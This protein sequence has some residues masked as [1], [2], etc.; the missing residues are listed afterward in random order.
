[1][2]PFIAQ[3]ILF[4]G[5]FV[6]KGWA[7]C[8]GQVLPINAYPALFG[9]LGTTYGGDGRTTFALPDLRGRV[10]AHAGN[11]PGLS[12]RRIGQMFGT[13]T[14]TLTANQI[15]TH[16]HTLMVATSTE[17]SQRAGGGQFWSQHNLCTSR[18]RALGALE[19][20]YRGTEQ[21]RAGPRQYAAYIVHQLHHRPRGNFPHAR[22]KSRKTNSAI[23][24][25][26]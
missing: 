23:G 3:I 26:E 6:P 17:V 14:V 24:L 25:P 8:D 19:R 13:E 7:F 18:S 20:E 9:L 21:W 16:S 11:G 4:G 10:P 12:P 5:N 22:I 2:E 15:P 1:M